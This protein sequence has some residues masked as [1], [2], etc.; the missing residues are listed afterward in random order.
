MQYESW[1]DRQI[2]EATE[3]GAFDNLPGAGKP[4]NLDPDEDWWIKA[5]LAREDL[6]ALLPG[7]LQ[8]RREVERIQDTLADVT[9]EEVA[10]EI[11]DDLKARIREHYLRPGTGPRIIVRLVDVEAEL[12]AWRCR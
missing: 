11:L 3:R 8:L 2:R 6:G 1:I 5:K 4:L 7:P 10:R 12:D 9:R